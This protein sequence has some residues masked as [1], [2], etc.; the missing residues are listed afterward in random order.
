MSLF[1]NVPIDVA[2]ESV[3]NGITYKKNVN[4]RKQIFWA[5]PFV[6][7]STYFTF[8]NVI[9]KQP[10]GTSMGSSLSSI[11]ANLVLQSLENTALRLL[12]NQLS[13]FLS[14]CW[15]MYGNPFIWYNNIRTFQLIPSM[16]PIHF[17]KRRR[18][19]KLF[20]YNYEERR[21]GALTFVS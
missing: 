5:V 13:F 19:T 12:N 20:G 11:I 9:Y 6:L 1:T 10:F 18:V 15:H 3:K 8:D 17:G 16:T 4:F 7:S 14:I 2:L 21:E